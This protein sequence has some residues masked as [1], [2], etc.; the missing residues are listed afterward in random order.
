[1]FPNFSD[2][3]EVK[4]APKIA[5]NCINKMLTIR[6]IVFSSSG[7]FISCSPKYAAINKTV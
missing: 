1:M 2:N 6:P 3:F 7:Q 4:I 5:I